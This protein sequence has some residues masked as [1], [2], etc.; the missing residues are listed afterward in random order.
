MKTVSH[1]I[2]M[3]YHCPEA[4]TVTEQLG[5]TVV[6]TNLQPIGQ[7]LLGG[8]CTFADGSTKVISARE[9]FVA[10]T[11][12]ALGL[13]AIIGVT[14]LFAFMSVYIRWKKSTKAKEE[15]LLK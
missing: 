8:T 14:S 15:V 7:T 4:V 3:A 9:Y 11:V 13:G 12:G 6:D 1:K 5:S 2:V 10:T